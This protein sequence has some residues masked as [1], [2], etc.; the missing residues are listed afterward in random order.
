MDVTRV[1]GSQARTYLVP[2]SRVLRFLEVPQLA[3]E[4]TEVLQPSECSLLTVHLALPPPTS[5]RGYNVPY[6]AIHWL[7]VDI[8]LGIFDCYRLDENVN[9]NL[10]LA[11]CKLSHVCQRWRHLLHECAFHLGIHIQ[12]TN[13]TPIVDT[14]DHLPPL[15]LFI[16]YRHSHTKLLTEQDELGIY[17]LLQLH[18]RV[19][20]IH[21]D[22]PASILRKVFVLMD[23]HFP[24]LVYLSFSIAATSSQSGLTFT[25]PKAFLSPN[26]C[27]LV[28]PSVSPPKRLRFLTST[29]SLVTL[30]LSN[31]QTSSYFRPRVLV[32]R[33]RSLPHL[34]ELSIEFSVPVPRPRTERQLLG[35]QGAPM[36]LPSL[37]YLRFKGVSAYLESLV[38]Q[39][40]APCLK[41]LGITLFNQIAFALPHQSHLINITEAFKFP[42]AMVYFGHDEVSITMADHSLAWFHFF[43]LRVKCTQ[44]DWQIDCAAQICN[45]LISALSGVE[46]LALNCSDNFQIPTEL[47]NDAI[48]GR[49]WHEL[50][51]SFIGVNQLHVYADRLLEELS[52]ALQ[53]DEVGSD[54]GFLPHLRSIHAV[55]NRFTSFI[56]TRRAVGGPVQFLRRWH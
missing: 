43:S 38:A 29:V 13:G 48:D 3:G 55:D 22:L 28:F 17:H 41:R 35:E 20:H 44:F 45:A 19:R 37:T 53:L 46:R 16:D 18:D 8:L 39:I 9:W 36:T 4:V 7:N 11:W 51:R 50:L 26:L 23:E 33:L 52:Y 14:L 27:H 5:E 47:Q 21:L 24:I 12:C 42:N 31:I 1:F 6:P 15:P 56:N 30:K 2:Q 49:T 10:R 25:L 32:A 34:V 40:R 54:L